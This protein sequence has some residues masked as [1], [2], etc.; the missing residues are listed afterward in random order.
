MKARILI[1]V[2][3]ALCLVAL[4]V[5]RASVVPKTAPSQGPQDKS[6]GT[7]AIAVPQILSYQGKLT[8]TT[9]IPVPD[10]NYS[11]VFR[12]YT[13]PS[14]GSPIWNETQGVTTKAGLFSVLLGSVTPIGSMPD[15]GAAYLAM[16][17]DGGAE[18][19][20]RL[21]LA[22]S[23]YAYLS[24]R[25]A[26]ADLLQGRD[27]A[28][29]A[30]SGHNHDAA[31]V[32]E[33]QMSSVTSNM[34]ADGTI[35]AADFS[36][37]GASSGQVMKWTGSAWAPRN[38]SVGGGG[39]GGTVTSVSQATGAVCTPNPI[40][41]TGTVGF[42]AT[43]G[44]GRYVNEAQSAGGDLTGTYPSPTL[45]TSGVSAGSYGSATQVGTF[46]VD[47][48]G[49][50]TAAS[51]TTISGVPPGGTAGGG[52]TGTYP[53]PTVAADAVSSGNIVNGSV[54]AA[55]IRDT[56]VNTA[57]L[58]DGAITSAKI[59]DG[60]VTSA[61]IRDTTVN[62]AE[63]KDAAV[64]MPKLN[65][66]GAASG[67]VIKW[68]GSAW[69]PRNDSLGTGTV[70]RCSSGTGITC[71]PNPITTTG[72]IALNT[73]YTD[74]RYILNQYSSAQTGNHW[75]SGYG[76]AAQFYGVAAS[77]GSPAVYGDGGSYAYGLYG[78]ATT[79][80][81]AGVGAF[82]GSTT[83]GLYSF[84]NNATH[85]GARVHNSH[86]T[87][88]GIVSTGNGASA[89]YL[90]GGSGGAFVGTVCGGY[91]RATNTSGTAYGLYGEIN[92]AN[93][94]GSFAHNSNTSGTG[95]SGIGNNASGSHL[96]SGSGVAGTG[97]QYGVYGYA[98]NSTN[99]TA[100]GYFANGYGS[101]AYVAYY[102][103]TNYKIAGSGTVSTIMDTRRG[104]KT[105]FAPEMPEAYFE[106]AG[107]GQLVK[108][109][110]RIDLE[111]LFS[112]CIKVDATHRLKVFV[113]L[114]DDCN[115]VYVKKD[116]TGFDVYELQGG[117]SN[118]RFSWRV[119]AKWKGNE[120]VRLPDAPGPQ[121]SETVERP[122]TVHTQATTATS[123]TATPQPAGQP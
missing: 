82:G 70:T 61:G 67:Q 23:A 44:D 71:T 120:G 93:G 2:V 83:H 46:T 33:G 40:T 57:D 117:S 119:L 112:D 81:A 53:N 84:A 87:G 111:A 123:L 56:T 116:E 96:A 68:T 19:T 18:L 100:G 90:T 29:F 101:Y 15:A 1:L 60:A 42:D 108:G 31:Y 105:L 22:S 36:Q 66:A 8:D 58:K 94:F 21:R 88:T 104:K 38:D 35:A 51:N 75:I 43:W 17:V 85:F 14:G 13:T 47:A 79:T 73:T 72:N 76:R 27:T 37:M 69:A 92:N 11:V 114:E 98:R 49:R 113:Q 109:H 118:A 30:P 97:T 32:N 77:S 55:D 80:G 52:L 54:T 28:A 110:C 59:Q 63:L 64:T 3:T 107:E 106:D 25:A 121:P 102:N 86:A 39:G 78:T 7:E 24:S 65:Q 41:T 6:Y 103:G 5:D 4:A 45:G 95:I 91:G 16:A 10:G 48:K 62:T 99:P 20:P 89:T 9:G 50:L 34:I 74:G 12:L 122:R 26:S 115:G